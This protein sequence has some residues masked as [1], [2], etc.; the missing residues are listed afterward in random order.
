MFTKSPANRASAK[1]LLSDSWLNTAVSEAS[2]VH[3][4]T[5][6]RN[7]KNFRGGCKFRQATLEYIAWQF[8]P[9]EEA[10]A[11]KRIFMA[12]DSDM[13]GKLSREDLEVNFQEL[14][15]TGLDDLTRIMDTMDCDGSGYI[16]FHEFLTATLNWKR[17]LTTEVMESAFKAFD[18]DGN[19][20]IEVEEL[21]FML[22]GDQEVENGVWT[23]VL[24][25]V[26]SDG[27]GA[28]W[29]I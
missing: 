17:L 6:L 2:G 20:R 28:V 15:P 22:Q 14:L 16:E 12:M 1:D 23:D 10:D 24:Q 21:K 29:S 3:K 8:A 13:D 25:E 4:S 18:K 11:I 5:I 7:I 27:D 26:D 19:G 9:A